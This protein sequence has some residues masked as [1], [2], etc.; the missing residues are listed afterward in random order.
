MASR[1][2]RFQLLAGLLIPLGI[3]ALVQFSVTYRNAE[4]TARAVTD[5]ILLASAR[6]IAEHI[7]F[8][9]AGVDVTVPPAALGMFDLG[10]GDTVYYR[11]TR[12][13]G[14]L[15]AGYLDLPAPPRPA[16]ESQPEYYDA[17]YRDDPIRLVAVT[18][19][20]SLANGVQIATVVVAETLNGRRAMSRELWIGSALQQSLLIA[21]ACVLAW[22]ALRRVLAPLLR[23]SYEV[24]ARRPD[25]FR[26]FSIASLQAELDPLMRALNDY[27]MRLGAQL[28]AQRRF[29]ANAAHQLRTPLTLLRMQASYALRGADARER[30]EATEAFLATTRQLTRLTN[31][32]LSLAKAEPHGQ[33]PSRD[34]ID[35]VAV[36]RDIL[37]EHGRLA[38]DRKIDLG[39]DVHETS[40]PAIICAD[41]T[42]LRDLIV[43]LV[44]N[45]VRYTPPGGQ[46][47]VTVVREPDACLLRVEDTGPGIPEAQRA[48]VF[49]R[50]YRIS[51]SDTE[52]S[53]LGLAIVKEIV[54]AHGATIT[55][56]DRSEGHGL[57]VEVRWHVAAED[58]T[59]RADVAEGGRTPLEEPVFGPR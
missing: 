33:P 30:Q 21:I 18:Q 59:L 57:V 22:L 34:P 9:E 13:D 14:R 58:A 10:Y 35:L 50:F 46:V 43:N 52:G 2:L 12:S 15:L 40:E 16:A 23:L 44:D 56:G 24:E 31:Q 17:R 38:V 32:L 37:V 11:V 26:P 42:T 54:D 55:L 29:I 4:V 6:S 53:G 5:R 49:E 7:G 47:N 20:V 27:M 8:G 39:F 28:E 36:T 45:A 1:S 25:D 48:L 19:P 3:V 41:P 51:G